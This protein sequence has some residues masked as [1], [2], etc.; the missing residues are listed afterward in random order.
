LF[1]SRIPAARC[2]L[3]LIALALAIA[4]VGLGGDVALAAGIQWIG[5][6]TASD[7]G[8]A[9][10]ASLAS[11]R[12][13][14]AERIYSRIPDPADQARGYS[15]TEMQRLGARIGVGLSLRAPSGVV[16]TG[17]C[18]MSPAVSAYFARLSRSVAAGHPVVVPIASGGAG[19]Y[20]LLVG[21]NGEGFSVLDPGSPGL[22]TMSSSALASATCGFGYVAL[23][24]R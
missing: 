23:E 17:E 8:R 3:A 7:C 18:S 9:V 19:H 2:A 20:L 13:Q 22:R 5:Q 15:I 11:R 24:A 14:D 4:I 1:S 6:K 10:L 16:I 12:G 21:T